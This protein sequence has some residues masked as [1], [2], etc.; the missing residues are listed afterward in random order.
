VLLAE[1]GAFAL[2]SLDLLARQAAIWRDLDRGLLPTA[3]LAGRYVQNPVGIDQELD[4]ELWNAGGHRRNAPQLAFAQTATV[5]GQ[6]ALAL[7]HV[8]LDR[9]LAVDKSR[10]HFRRSA[11]DRRVAKN[12]LAHCA[13]HRL[14][15]KG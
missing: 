7:E 9:R 2:D 10:E 8:D 11:R 13:A 3:L 5:A 15:A 4:F 1:P 14:D 6:L 12:Q